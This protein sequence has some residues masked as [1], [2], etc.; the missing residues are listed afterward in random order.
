MLQEGAVRYCWLLET[1]RALVLISERM[2]ATTQAPPPAAATALVTHPGP[3]ARPWNSDVACAV[4][5]RGEFNHSK[6]Q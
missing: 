2:C 3:L 1:Q 6:A 5:Y 4:F